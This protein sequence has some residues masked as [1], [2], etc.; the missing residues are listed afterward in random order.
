LPRLAATL[1]VIALLGAT[2]AAFAVTENLK[3]EK[4]PVFSTRV[5][6]IFSPV[7]GCGTR[8]ANIAFRL[9]KTDR[10][11]LVIV[12]GDTVVRTLVSGRRFRHGLHHFTWNGRDDEGQLLPQGFYNPRVHLEG[13]HRTILLPNPI[14]I[15]T[16]RPVVTLVGVKPRVFSP[17][18]NGHADFVTVSYRLSEP[19]H[20]LVLVDGHVRVRGRS[21]KV[22]DSLHWYGSLAGRKVPPGRYRIAVAGRDIAGNLSHPTRAVV[23]RLRYV[24]ILKPVLRVRAGRRF[25][26]PLST[27]AKQVRWRLAGKSAIAPS[28][29]L[30]LLVKRPGRYVL[31]VSVGTH[32]AR[33]T[34]VAVRKP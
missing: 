5:D 33:A 4:S 10:L 14:R 20:V 7:C 26:I 16:T 32:A 1:L 27:D 24:E 11:D 18:G 2:A 29:G 34:V 28:R 9:R 19:A 22:V 13:E 25:R 31:Y 8:V 17:D 23:V 21:G 6:K 15:D 30:R 12:R 3:L